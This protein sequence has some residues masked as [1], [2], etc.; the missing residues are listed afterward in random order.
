ML[1][2]LTSGCTMMLDGDTESPSKIDFGTIESV[3]VASASAVSQY[4]LIGGYGGLLDS[5][6]QVAKDPEIATHLRLDTR[7]YTIRDESGQIVSYVTDK[8]FLVE[9]DCVAIE[10]GIP[11]NLRLVDDGICQGNAPEKRV[12]SKMEKAAALCAL[13]K[14]RLLIALGDAQIREA[15][16]RVHDD[17]QY[18]R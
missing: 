17:C 15:N 18:D 1:L 14:R 4:D 5:S 6:S 16:K 7:R 2:V 13:D 9:G 12:M 10:R 3:E 8:A 11:P